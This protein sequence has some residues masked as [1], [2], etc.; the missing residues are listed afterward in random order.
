MCWF[1]IGFNVTSNFKKKIKC[2]G[3]DNINNY[4]DPK[5]KVSRLKLLKKQKF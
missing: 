5:L 4:Y 1:F 3:I 2:Y